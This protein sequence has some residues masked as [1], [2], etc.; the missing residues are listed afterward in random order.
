MSKNAKGAL[1]TTM[2]GMCWGLSGSMGQYL[3]TVQ[4]MDARWLTPIRLFLAGVILFFYR[5]F[6]NRASLFDILKHKRSL[7]LLACYGLLGVAFCQLT[8]FMTIQYSNAGVGTIMQDLSPIMILVMSC[9][10]GM[11]RP[12]WTEILSLI[13]ALVG[14]YLI[15]THGDPKTLSV[16]PR[17]LIL[18]VLSAVGVTVYNMIAPSLTKD[19]PVTVLQA[20]SF[21]AGGIFVGILGQGYEIHYV[22][23]AMGIFGILFVIAVGN[24][25][26][27]TSYIKGVQYIGPS[28]GILYGFSEP[29]TA[30]LIATVLFHNPFGIFDFLGFLCIFLM[31]LLISISQEN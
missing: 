6:Q 13:L 9:I 30:A 26:A 5:L 19:Y 29:V 3:F 1:L 23:N 16:S 28:K 4:G 2:G 15:V 27:F 12:K 7:L 8:Y 21:L 18:G 31:L 17:A 10:L 24:L 14:V 25:L 22:P 11:R 20:W